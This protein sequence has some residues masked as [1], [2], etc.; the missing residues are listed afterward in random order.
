MNRHSLYHR[1][2]A[3]LGSVVYRFPS[4]KLYVVGVT[5]TKGKSTTVELMGALFEATGARTAVLSSVTR[6]IGGTKERNM[7]GNSMPGRAAIQKFLREAVRAGCTHAFIEVTS[8]GVVQHRHECIE[9]DA[10]AFLNL[11]PEHIEAHGSFEAYRD[12]K[13]SFF[14]YA[15][16]SP[17]KKKLFLVNEADPAHT[18]FEEAVKHHYGNTVIRFSGET[19]L[20]EGLGNHFD[21]RSERTHKKLGEWLFAEFNLENA[22]A[23]VALAE[24]NG[25]SWDEIGEALSGF[26][27]VP[28]RLEIVQRKPFTV[29]VD[30]AHTPDSLRK[31]YMTAKRDYM[32][33]PT[34]GSLIAVLGSAGGGRDKWKR[35]EMGRIAGALCTD[36]VLTNEDPYDE[37]PEEIVDG[38]KEGILHAGFPVTHLHREMDRRAAIRKA[39]LLAKKGDAVVCTGKGSELWIH[40]AEGKKVPWN[41]REEVEAALGDAV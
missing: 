35:A 26:K 21:L 13:V 38:I 24:A 18:H 33:N 12:A 8:Q 36:I 16:R 14:A 3:L 32:D 9:W 39:L 1:L 34:G 7:T 5:G 17:K 27:G 20:R 31:V 10:A 28:G 22:A 23:A 19:F 6:K 41:E 29:I 15:A 25:A 11:A 37:P 4:R 30:Y 2:W 40:E